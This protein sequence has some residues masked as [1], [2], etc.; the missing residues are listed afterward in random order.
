MSEQAQEVPP[1]VVTS[2]EDAEAAAEVARR[3]F[4]DCE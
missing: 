4:M 2:P 1:V 3:A